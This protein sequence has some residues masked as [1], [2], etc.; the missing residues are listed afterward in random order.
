MKATLRPLFLFDVADEI[1]TNTGTD[2]KARPRYLGFDP[3]PLVV[4]TRNARVA[5]FEFGVVSVTLAV[6]FAGDWQSLAREVSRILDDAE[7]HARARAVA[8]EVLKE[9]K[10]VNPYEGDWLSEDYLIIEREGGT[11]EP[12]QR[13]I[14][15][16]VRGES[17]PLSDSETREVMDSALSCY[18]H[19]LLVAG[20]AAAYVVDTAEGAQST[21]QLLEF[22]NAQLLELRH[23]DRRLQDLLTRLQRLQSRRRRPWL[24]RRWGSVRE[25]ERLNEMRLD[26]MTL[27]E[28]SDNSL[29][30]L[31]DM[32]YAR[33]YRV[34]AHRIGV[35]DYRKLL[36][37]KLKVAGECYHFL[38]E[39]FNHA[40][41]FLLEAVVVAILV[42]ELGMALAKLH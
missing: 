12:A 24:W 31:G 36:E 35:D 42:I 10:K 5:I 9:L 32:F 19:D 11:E 7:V 38:V 33:A 26:V 27:M 21:L 3:P 37:E 39:E 29:R 28:R 13:E 2:L 6:P 8:A 20:W 30:V 22:A 15:A 18:P 23:Y 17:Q 14:A 16:L 25:A 40:R 41:A 1:E 4:E 34:V